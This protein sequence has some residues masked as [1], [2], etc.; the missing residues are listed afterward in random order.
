MKQLSV[1]SQL[2]YDAYGKTDSRFPDTESTEETVRNIM[3]G[4]HGRYLSDAS[5]CSGAVPSVVSACL[6]VERMSGDAE[7]M[8]VFTHPLYRARGLATTEITVA[9]NQLAKSGF[10]RVTMWIRESNDVV[11]RLLSKMDF[12]ITQRVVEMESSG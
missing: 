4:G 1:L 8:Q 10:T 11:K 5:F 9:M 7:I 2:M 12:V 6:L 3:S